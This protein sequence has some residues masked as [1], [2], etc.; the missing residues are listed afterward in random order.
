M[1]ATI[2]Q[3]AHVTVQS[4]RLFYSICSILQIYYKTEPTKCNMEANA[5]DS[6]GGFEFRLFRVQYRNFS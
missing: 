5:W 1:C 6:V 2:E 4:L 3:F